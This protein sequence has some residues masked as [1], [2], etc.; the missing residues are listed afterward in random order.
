MDLHI[1]TRD[2][3]GIPAFNSPLRLGIYIHLA[4]YTSPDT[5]HVSVKPSVLV[6]RLSATKSQIETSINKL[7]EMGAIN[8]EKS[9]VSRGVWEIDMSPLSYLLKGDTHE[10]VPKQTP[11]KRLMEAWDNAHKEATGRK[12]LRSGGDFWRERN[13]WIILFDEIGTDLY[14]SI[15]RFF[16]DQ[17]YAKYRY[18][19]K[20]FFKVASE[21]TE[22]K[23]NTGWRYA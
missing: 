14:T 13:D 12:Y 11:I 18:S 15:D 21:L 7:A 2:V 22:E 9:T 20:V 16:E 3:M 23:V 8:L 5:L 6:D 1:L 4:A 17:K 19:F 10:P